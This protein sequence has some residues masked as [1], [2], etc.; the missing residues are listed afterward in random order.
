MA[1]SRQS[2]LQELYLKLKKRFEVSF[3]GIGDLASATPVEKILDLTSDT[4]VEDIGEIPSSTPVVSYY[5]E[6]IQPSSLEKPP[7]TSPPMNMLGDEIT[8]STNMNGFS[9][10]KTSF[11]DPSPFIKICKNI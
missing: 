1:Y 7:I 6:A 5:E 8:I 4:I 3:E 9:M 2:G 10:P 11:E